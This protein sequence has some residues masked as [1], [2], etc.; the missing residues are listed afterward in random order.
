M[1][2]YI[3]ICDSVYRIRRVLGK[4]Q[5]CFNGKWLSEGEFV[6]KLIELEK[7]DHV[8]QLAL[9]GANINERQKPN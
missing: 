5:V 1:S 3:K 6:D 2:N 7:W 9:F 8:E 4:G